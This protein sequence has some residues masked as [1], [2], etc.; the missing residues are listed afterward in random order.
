MTMIYKDCLEG[1]DIGDYK[2]SNCRS[3]EKG[4]LRGA[5]YIN[6]SL[7]GEIEDNIE[8]A[9]WWKSNIVGGLILLIPSTRG[10]FDGGTKIT[11][12]GLGNDSEMTI[13]KTFS[14][15]VND[16]NHT[17]NKDFYEA[18]EIKYRDYFFCFR[19]GREVRVGLEVIKSMEIKDPVE[20]S[21]DSVVTWQANIVWTQD[22]PELLV[23]IYKLTDAVEDLFE[24]VVEPVVKN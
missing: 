16:V 18:L 20:E 14:A 8:D 13:G 24:G 22:R 2:Y 11:T 19:T 10:T 23:P 5:A 7:K 4:G 21:V 15:L 1:I 6:K 12:T 9:E 3:T 17:E